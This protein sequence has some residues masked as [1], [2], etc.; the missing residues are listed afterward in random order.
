MVENTPVD[1]ERP[2][3]ADYGDLRELT[4]AA[5]TGAFTDATF[6]THTPFNQLTFS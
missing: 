4:E 1:Y 5:S 6:G 3:I 2:E